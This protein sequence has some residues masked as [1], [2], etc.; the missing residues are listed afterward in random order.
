M[1]FSNDILVKEITGQDI[2][3]A[4]EFGVRTL[5]EPNK[6]FPQVSGITYKIDIGI[7]SS[8]II[9]DNETFIRVDGERR[10]YE[11]KVNE[12][13]LNLLKKYTISSSSFIFGGGN[14]FS[15]F[16]KYGTVKQS[17][18]I[19]YE[20]LLK[21]IEEY[22]GGS[23]PTK[24]KNKE[25]RIIKTYGQ[26]IN[27][28]D[29]EKDKTSENKEINESNENKEINESNEN[30]EIN[31]SN[32]NK[33]INESN[34]NKEINEINE[35]NETKEINDSHET[36]ITNEIDK[37]KEAT[38]TNNNNNLSLIKINNNYLFLIILL[39]F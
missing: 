25:G 2:L 19:E 32:E 38:K 24:Y 17:I 4:L 6:N 14:G 1:P 7:S 8:V 29:K 18:G 9:D 13:P 12:E 21:Y 33:E 27:S 37:N 28:E 20:L 31:E 5:P 15:M 36:I 34:E 35:I 39:V 11:V 22:L 10:V 26:V 16:A 3:D 30:K 23:I